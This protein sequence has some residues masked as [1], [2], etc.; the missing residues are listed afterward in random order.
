MENR[1]QVGPSLISFDIFHRVR[2]FIL[3]YII[4]DITPPDYF[5]KFVTDDNHSEQ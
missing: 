5:A 3:C 4:S 1:G 2:M